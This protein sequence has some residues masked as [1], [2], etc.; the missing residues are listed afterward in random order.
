MYNTDQSDHKYC[1]YLSKIKKDD[2]SSNKQ[3]SS[4]NRYT[5]NVHV[6]ITVGII[7]DYSKNHM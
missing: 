7:Y 6:K 2:D 1:N 3:N 4:I 5:F